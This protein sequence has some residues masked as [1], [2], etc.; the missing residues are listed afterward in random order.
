MGDHSL[1]GSDAMRYGGVPPTRGIAEMRLL[2]PAANPLLRTLP[3][4]NSLGSATP[5]GS[6]LDALGHFR[7]GPD[8]SRAR[9][10]GLTGS[11]DESGSRRRV[12]T[13]DMLVREVLSRADADDARDKANHRGRPWLEFG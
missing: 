1:F 11:P 6:C 5:A 3:Q 9:Y 2:A 4:Q 8:P 13:A 10:A 12:E 7:L